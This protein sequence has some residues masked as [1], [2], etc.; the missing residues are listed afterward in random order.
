MYKAKVYILIYLSMM[1]PVF[2]SAAP[3]DKYYVPPIEFKQQAPQQQMPLQQQAPSSSRAQTGGS[4]VYTKFRN[5]VG[6]LSREKR[7]ELKFSFEKKRDTASKTH[8]PDAATYYQ[9][10]INILNSFQQETP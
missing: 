7:R 9:D 5:E 3:I 2:L 4:D 8:N 6:K 1:L 10:L